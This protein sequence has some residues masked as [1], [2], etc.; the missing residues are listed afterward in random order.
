MILEILTELFV[1]AIGNPFGPNE[2]R[3]VYRTEDGGRAGRKFFLFLRIQEHAT[4][5]FILKILILYMQ[6]YGRSDEN[7]GQ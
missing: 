6:R 7:H 5:N 3:G 2:E 1:A 4:L